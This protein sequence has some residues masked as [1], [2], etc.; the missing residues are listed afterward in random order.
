[1]SAK[2]GIDRYRPGVSKTPEPVEVEVESLGSFLI[3]PLR[4]ADEQTV[5]AY[6]ADLRTKA[7]KAEREAG[8]REREV[9]A[10]ERD[11]ELTGEERKKKLAAAAK[12]LAEAQA[13]AEAADEA[14]KDWALH[15]D[16]LYVSAGLIEP[17]MS[18]QELRDEVGQWLVPQSQEFMRKALLATGVMSEEDFA[19]LRSR[20][21]Q[22]DD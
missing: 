6:L 12:A 18:G 1:M 8:K 22:A 19:S 13:A 21:R 9:K 16:Y 7:D 15:S 17:E 5:L 4:T 11:D 14:A 3:R 2:T 20:F 10:L